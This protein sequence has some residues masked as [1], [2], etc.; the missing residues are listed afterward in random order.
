MK[1]LSKAILHK[2]FGRFHLSFEQLESIILDIESHLNNL[3]LTYIYI[4]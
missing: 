2:T 3:A 4:N 1:G